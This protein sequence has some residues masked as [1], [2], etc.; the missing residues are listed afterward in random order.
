MNKDKLKY[1][2]I[3]ILVNV[4]MCI[5][6]RWISYQIG[7]TWDEKFSIRASNVLSFIMQLYFFLFVWLFTFTIYF[8]KNPK[9]HIFLFFLSS[10]FIIFVYDLYEIIKFDLSHR[11]V[12]YF[13]DSL[14]IACY[15]TL[16]FVIVTSIG[17]HYSQLYIGKKFLPELYKSK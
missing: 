3:A 13:I 14:K 12:G 11:G 7:Y 15:D 6:A 1:H 5:I 4:L 16:P 8:L 10:I 2:L 17:I 9:K